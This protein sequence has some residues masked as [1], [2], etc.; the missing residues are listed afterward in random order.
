MKSIIKQKII[1]FKVN[2][3]FKKAVN[4]LKKDPIMGLD[5]DFVKNQYK[6]EFIDLRNIL[7]EFDPIGL[8]SMG[9]PINEYEPEVKTIIVQL[10]NLKYES[11]VLDLVYNEFQRWFGNAGSK[12]SYKSLA[13]KI[14]AWKLKKLK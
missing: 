13:I 14:F 1:N 3:Q 8:L 9:A 10:N 6:E 2:T 7:N 11:E 5:L 12:D 4:K